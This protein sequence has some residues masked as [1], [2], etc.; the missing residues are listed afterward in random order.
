MLIITKFH[1]TFQYK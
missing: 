1:W